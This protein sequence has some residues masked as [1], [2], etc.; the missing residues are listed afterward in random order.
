MDINALFSHLNSVS[1]A[2]QTHWNFFSVVALGV[3][4]GVAIKDKNIETFIG[5]LL[6]VGLGLFLFSNF[7]TIHRTSTELKIVESEIEYQIASEN[8]TPEFKEFYSNEHSNEHSHINK[9][10]PVFH[11]TIDI[12]IILI[13]IYRTE[14][15]ARWI[16]SFRVNM[17]R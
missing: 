14:C 17:D 10:W 16:A 7:Q 15:V 12:F 13:L 1:N 5:V 11:I 4:T 3:G 8:V 9:N 6:I 2:I